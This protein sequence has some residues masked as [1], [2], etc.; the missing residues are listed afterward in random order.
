MTHTYNGLSPIALMKPVSN[1]AVCVAIFIHN[2]PNGSIDLLLLIHGSS[3][4]LKETPRFLV[5]TWKT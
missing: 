2:P 5:L 3:R 1:N 4:I